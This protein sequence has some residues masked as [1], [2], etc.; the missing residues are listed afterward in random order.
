MGKGGKGILLPRSE[1]NTTNGTMIMSPV[2][3]VDVRS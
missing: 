3:E 1:N 2:K